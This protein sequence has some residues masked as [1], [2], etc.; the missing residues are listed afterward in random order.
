[1]QQM[2]WQMFVLATEERDLETEKSGGKN[3][4]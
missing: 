3:I 4:E 2:T 1:M